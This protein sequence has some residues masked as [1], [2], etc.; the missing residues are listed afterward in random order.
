MSVQNWFF[1]LNVLGAEKEQEKTYNWDAGY[2]P[3]SVRLTILAALEEIVIKESRSVM[4]I[5]DYSGSFLSPK[6]SHFFTESYNTFMGFGGMRYLE[7]NYS[8]GTWEEFL[9]ENNR[10]LTNEYKKT[11]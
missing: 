2:A 4:L 1:C 6:F 11:E 10:D 3:A 8:D 5:G 7:A 9:R